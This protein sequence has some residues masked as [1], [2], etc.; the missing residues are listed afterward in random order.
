MSSRD[1]L[2]GFRSRR[3]ARDASRGRAAR[4]E[5]LEDAGFLLGPPAGEEALPAES[6]PARPR[7]W[8]RWL[9]GAS[10]RE[11]LARIVPGDPLGVRAMVARRLRADALLLDA[12]RVH[13]RALA[14]CAREAPAYRGRPPIEPWLE[15]NI[16]AAIDDLSHED[17]EAAALGRAS[18]I[19][20]LAR[21]LGLDP[22]AMQGA[23]REFSRL[24]AHDRRAFFALVLE[25]R[26]LDEVARRDGIS[27][28]E[29]ARRAR[30][31]LV[32]LASRAGPLVLP[33]SS[34]NEKGGGS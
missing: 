2:G 5:R 21:P 18:A 32:V 14:R 20:D 6:E 19:A 4:S 12:D 13:L 8:R 30:R 7:E 26:P 16:T 1:G 23:C 34:V 24:P 11:I 10:P 33:Q 29:A 25:Q 28:S 31:A 9:A 15:E 17:G 3:G 27:A 22:V